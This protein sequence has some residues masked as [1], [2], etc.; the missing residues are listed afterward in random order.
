MGS[1]LCE[2][3]GIGSC[4]DRGVAEAGAAFWSSLGG[5]GWHNPGSLLT[6]P[7]EPWPCFSE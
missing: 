7:A 3:C 2:C 5:F 6:L 1:G 4:V